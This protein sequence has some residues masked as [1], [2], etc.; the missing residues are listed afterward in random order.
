M[1]LPESQGG[2]DYPNGGFASGQGG[3]PMIGDLGELAARMGSIDTYDRR[4]S[5]VWMT[6]FESGLQGTVLGTDEGESE[7]YVSSARSFHGAFS[8]KLDPS[9]K[10]DSYVEWRRIVYFLPAGMVGFEVSLSLD[11]RPDNLHFI[12]KSYDGSHSLGARMNYYTATGNWEIRKA[13]GKYVTI[14]SGFKLQYST[15]SWHPVK[16]V[17]DVENERYVRALIG[18]NSIDLSDYGIIKTEAD[19]LAQAEVG[20]ACYGSAPAHA[21]IWIDGVIITQSEVAE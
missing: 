2:I 1:A 14:L 3:F 17:V 7:G 19:D 20:I 5:I 13:D 15:S 8:L 11:E 12:I 21:P 18:R 4:G 16:L 10:K 9:D 6:D